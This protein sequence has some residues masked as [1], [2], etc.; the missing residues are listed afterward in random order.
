MVD[1]TDKSKSPYLYYDTFKSLVDGDLYGYF[2]FH[3]S[4]ENENK[5]Y[6]FERIKEKLGENHTYYLDEL[7]EYMDIYLKDLRKKCSLQLKSKWIY[8]FFDDKHIDLEH[9]KNQSRVNN[10]FKSLFNSR[11]PDELRKEVSELLHLLHGEDTPPVFV[12]STPVEEPKPI[13]ESKSVE[14]SKLVE[15][16]KPIEEPKIVETPKP[17]E[18]PKLVETPKIVETPK[19]IETPKSIETNLDLGERTVSFTDLSLTLKKG[20]QIL[21]KQ[22]K[23]NKLDLTQ[24]K[25]LEIT[26][27][28][29]EDG[30]LY[31]VLIK[32]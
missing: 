21:L 11:L 19:P 15:E 4:D 14:E 9:T 29:V 8:A 13:E 23:A 30:I 18:E 1:T 17:I 31:N 25:D 20:S 5:D 7:I 3:S 22:V 6:W 12:V 10:A 16:S 32:Y 28:K 27:D 2:P 24:S 26:V